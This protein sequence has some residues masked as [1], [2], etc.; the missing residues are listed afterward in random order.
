MMASY[1]EMAEMAAR[2][3]ARF[4][5]GWIPQSPHEAARL[6]MWMGHIYK[7]AEE[8]PEYLKIKM[9]PKLMTWFH[10]LTLPEFS[11]FVDEARKTMTRNG[12]K[13]I[14]VMGQRLAEHI[15]WG[16]ERD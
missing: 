6:L 15:A 3:N 12:T 4:E 16:T 1:R 7:L 5:E 14:H 11:E 13:Y 8:N 2:Y 9:S 10:G